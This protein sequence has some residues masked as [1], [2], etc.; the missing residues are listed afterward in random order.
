MTPEAVAAGPIDSNQVLQ[1]ELNVTCRVEGGKEVNNKVT[2]NDLKW[3]PVS[4]QGRV[5]T[6]DQVKPVHSDIVIAKLAPGQSIR[7]TCYAYKGRGE[8]HAK[9]SPVATAHY[10]LL[11][12]VRIQKEIRNESA[13]KLKET[14]PSKVFDIEDGHAIVK[15]AKACTMCREC[16]RHEEW[17]D[18]IELAR[19]KRHFMF[20]IESTGAY[21]GKDI[22]VL[23]VK[24]LME[25]VDKIVAELKGIQKEA[26]NTGE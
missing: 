21:P 1:Y 4:D 26:T 15:N 16:L 24:E 19:A 25:T 14:C 13:R 2:S 10:K 17:T 22:F 3:V 9:W 20:S 11:P 18:K 7:A 8:T 12:I 23:A 6:E 5:Y